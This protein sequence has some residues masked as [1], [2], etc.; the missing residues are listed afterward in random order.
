MH[1]RKIRKQYLWLLAAAAILVQLFAGCGGQKV[2]RVYLDDS[3]IDMYREEVGAGDIVYVH[4]IAYYDQVFGQM[5]ITAADLWQAVDGNPNIPEKYRPVIKEFCEAYVTRAPEA[6]RRP[7]Y[8]NLLTLMVHEESDLYILAATGSESNVA[9]YDIADNS[10]CLRAD[11]EYVPGTWGYQSVFHEMSHAARIMWENIDGKNYKVESG[12]R[13][14][15]RVILDETLNTVF[16]VSLL[17]YDEPDIGYQLQSNIMTA[18][19]RSM[20]NY[21]PCDY[22]NH[23]Q[24][25]FLCKL[26]AF[27]AEEG[28]DGY[29]YP[30]MEVLHELYVF[31]YEDGKRVPKPRQHLLYDYISAVYYKNRINANTT[32]AEAKAIK[33]ELVALVMFDVPEDYRIDVKRFDRFLDIYC[34]QHGIPVS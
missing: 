24:S 21:E 7:L 29:A 32:Y 25:Y 12:G 20:D 31:H 5:D 30:M 4:D 8:R 34:K 9:F 33:D 26:D 19:L 23:S 6:D 2:E 28:Y 11:F 15:N 27:M 17:G 1:C 18:I 10:I 13:N 22:I 14:Y 16:S 3:K